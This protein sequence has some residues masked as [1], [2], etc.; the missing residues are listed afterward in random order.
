MSTRNSLILRDVLYAVLIVL[1]LMPGSDLANLVWAK[2]C[3]VVF[4]VAQR[5]WQHVT[6]Y[7]LT[8]K[9]Y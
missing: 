3:I 7:K 9:I 6:Y 4:G 8:G 1:V 2:V 5:I